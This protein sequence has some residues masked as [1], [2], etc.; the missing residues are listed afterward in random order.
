[1]LSFIKHHYKNFSIYQYYKK[2]NALT[3]DVAERQFKQTINAI[4][5]RKKIKTKKAVYDWAKNIHNTTFEILR[6]YEAERYWREVAEEQLLENAASEQ[7][8]QA[9][10]AFRLQINTAERVLEKAADE[11]SEVEG[12]DADDKQSMRFFWLSGAGRA[13]ED[14]IAKGDTQWLIGEYNLTSALHKYHN[15]VATMCQISDL[16]DIADVMAL[17]YVFHFPLDKTKG[18]WR[19]FPQDYHSSISSDLDIADG[20]VELPLDAVLQ[21]RK[22]SKM[23]KFQPE[24]MQEEILLYRS[25]VVKDSVQKPFSRCLDTLISNY[26]GVYDHE[27]T[28][29]A[30]FAER[31]LMPYL[32]YLFPKEQAFDIAGPTTSSKAAKSAYSVEDSS[33]IA[34]KP[35]V[36]ISKAGIECIAGEVKKPST[37]KVAVEKDIVKLANILKLMMDEALTSK[38]NK[39]AFVAGIHLNGIQCSTYKLDLRYDGVYRFSELGTFNVMQN[40]TDFL[41]AITA[42]EHFA[43]LKNVVDSAFAGQPVQN[44]SWRRPSFLPPKKLH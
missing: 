10:Q 43:Q 25:K 22:L 40:G 31:V 30:Q 8:R 32:R 1:M 27:E 21:C 12:D 16:T 3:R 37:R 36:L 5:E 23:A 14:L 13:K 38:S 42:Y 24:D 29:E 15:D 39:H 34:P 18:A 11:E 26:D 44:L 28:E 7:R 19:L 35:D 20:A 17:N 9:I 4:L 2:L 41:P 6:S 33:L